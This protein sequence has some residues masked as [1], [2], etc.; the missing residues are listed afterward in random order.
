MYWSGVR[1]RDNFSVQTVHQLKH[2]PL[3]SIE[4]YSS[5]EIALDSCERIAKM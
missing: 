2:F 3:G 5:F 4:V 1:K